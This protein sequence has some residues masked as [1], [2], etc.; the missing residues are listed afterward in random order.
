MLLVATR[1]HC[2]MRTVQHI[3]DLAQKCRQAGRPV[4]VQSKIPLNCGNKRIQ[5]DLTQIANI[6]LNERSTI[7]AVAEKTGMKKSTVHRRFKEGELRRHSNSL[8]PL[9]KEANK[10]QRLR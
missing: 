1:F 2:S 10:T 3:W 4:D 5:A 8:K 6:P 7:R 9:L